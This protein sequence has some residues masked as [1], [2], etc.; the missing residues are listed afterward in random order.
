MTAYHHSIYCDLIH[1]EDAT[2][3]NIREFSFSAHCIKVSYRQSKLE[4]AVSAAA[5]AAFTWCWLFANTNHVAVDLQLQ[6]S[7]H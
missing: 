4:N 2:N 6:P 7:Y 1:N 3:Q 5:R